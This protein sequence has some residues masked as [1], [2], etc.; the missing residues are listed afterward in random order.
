MKHLYYFNTICIYILLLYQMLTT[1]VVNID[2]RGR[3]VSLTLLLCVIINVFN[4]K[5]WTKLLCSK[6]IIIWFI[7]CTYTTI[8]IVL[9]GHKSYIDVNGDFVIYE[10]DVFYLQ[11]IFRQLVIMVTIAWLFIYN[12]KKLITH[13]SFIFIISALLILLFDSNRDWGGD[14][15]FGAQIGNNGALMMVTLIFILLMSLSKKYINKYVALVF[16]LVA[17]FIIFAIQTRKALVA[18]FIIFTISYLSNVKKKS[19]I[20]WFLI[21]I[22]LLLIGYIINFVMDNTAIGSRFATLEDQGEVS[23]ITN[24]PL[25]NIFGDRALHVYL[26]W[27]IWLD[28]PI[29]GV[30][31]CNAPYYSK[32]PYIFHQEYI[33]ELSENGIIG[34][35]LLVLF[36]FFIIKGISS[37]KLNKYYTINV[38]Y[39]CFGYIIAVLFISLTAWTYQFPHYFV[40]FGIIIGQTLKIYK[41][42][43]NY[44]YRFSNGRRKRT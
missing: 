10:N 35:Y 42:E 37:I 39:L 26:G 31:L 8:N 44:I 18:V 34:F 16:I 20:T 38:Q 5:L 24:I 1:L 40:A 15:R 13:V 25:L 36:Y 30:G 7:W 2:L 33:G 22:G 14:S 29:F 11:I 6:P 9:Q 43:E 21:P 12:E 28:N 4:N 17:I 23:N 3:I 32:L 27:N 19:P 41:N